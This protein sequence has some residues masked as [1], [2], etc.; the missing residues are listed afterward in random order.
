MNVAGIYTGCMASIDYVEL[1]CLSNLSFLRGASHPEELV[2]RAAELGYA[3]LAITDECSVSGV[4][5]AHEE[6]REHDFTLIVGTELRVDAQLKLVVLARDRLGYGHLSELIS[7]ARRAAEKGEYALDRDDLI[8]LRH[9]L[10]LWL[11]DAEPD[12]ATGE[13]LAARFAGRCWIGVELFGGPADRDRLSQLQALGEQLT[14]PLV[15]AGDVHMHVPERQ[16]LQDTLTAIRLNTPLADCGYALFPNAERHLRPL[17]RLQR[18]HPPELLAATLDIA[19]RCH[20][21]LDELR[22]EYPEELI[23][24]GET[25]ASHLR[26]LAM[27]GLRWRYPD[28][29]PKHARELVDKELA[30]IAELEFEPYFLTVHDLVQDT[31]QATPVVTARHCFGCTAG[32]GS[33]C[34]GSTV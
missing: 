7:H 21:S 23:P 3:G 19:R 14:L 8:G 16:A 12:T 28:G 26:Q 4:V 5:R 33:S 1:H 9:C 34:G 22:Y 13:W 30:L 29:V 20:F 15:S 18:I 25:P 10:L 6:A 2:T 27:D 32:A 24:P 17:D 11:P 31:L